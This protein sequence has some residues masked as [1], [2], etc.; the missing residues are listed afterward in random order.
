MIWKEISRCDFQWAQR[1]TCPQIA[2]RQ[3]TF[4][5]SCS[6]SKTKFPSN[7]NTLWGFLLIYSHESVLC[8]GKRRE[9]GVLSDKDQG[10]L[11]K[12]GFSW[13]PASFGLNSAPV[14]REAWR[15]S[16]RNFSE[17]VRPWWGEELLGAQLEPRPP[18]LCP[19]TFFVQN[20]CNPW[21]P[22]WEKL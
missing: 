5:G 10:W 12:R 2:K 4:V 8:S 21:P 7:Q 1:V 3:V 11:E 9:G 20:R 14:W 6:Y 15:Q 16:C 19:C 13:F 17:L 18:L 22:G